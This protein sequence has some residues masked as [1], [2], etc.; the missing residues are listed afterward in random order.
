MGTIEFLLTIVF[1]LA[2]G[3]GVA[4]TMGEASAADFLIARGSF[5]VAACSA[6]LAF[7]FWFKE[8]QHSLY[9]TTFIGA[10]VGLWVFVAL[11]LQ[12]IWLDARQH[13]GA[14]SKNVDPPATPAI[15][16]P[17]PPPPNLGQIPNRTDRFGDL[18]ILPNAELARLT[19]QFTTE[20]RAFERNIKRWEYPEMPSDFMQLPTEQK[21]E[22][23][24]RH[25]KQVMDLS[26]GKDAAFRDALFSDMTAIVQELKTRLQR[27]GI[28][29]PST[30]PT[31]L[32]ALRGLLAGAHPI[33]DVASYMEEMVR[34]LPI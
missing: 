15:P 8:G 7:W 18:A 24:K 29:V 34:R 25:A 4:I 16:A 3:T 20:M 19:K 21:D 28:L 30:G 17:A 5:I 10:L 26:N 33:G 27:S 9:L 12:F 32:P 22:L 1:A 31:S 14:H 13:R 2:F 11:P 6:A 23:F